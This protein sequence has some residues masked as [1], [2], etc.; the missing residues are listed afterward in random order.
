VLQQGHLDAGDMALAISAESGSAVRFSVR[1][2]LD[3]SFVLHIFSI[4]GRK[5]WEASQE[6]TGGGE[7][8]FVWNPSNVDGLFMAVLEAG[9]TRLSKTFAVVR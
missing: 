2:P 5:L 3:N 1:S 8:A 4:E 9:N 7:R 6:K